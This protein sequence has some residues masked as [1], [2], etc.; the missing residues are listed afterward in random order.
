LGARANES[1][2]LPL[3]GAIVGG[4]QGDVWLP[5]SASWDA[6]PK[7][8]TVVSADGISSAVAT[9]DRSVSILSV[10]EQFILGTSKNELDVQAVVLYRYDVGQ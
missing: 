1:E 7:N 10:N 5:E 8:Y 6:G 4:S 2:P 3:F 9:F